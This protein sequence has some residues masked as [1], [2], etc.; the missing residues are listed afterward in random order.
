MMLLFISI[1]LLFS[2]EYVWAM[3]R[4][5]D[6]IS[7]EKEKE[8]EFPNEK[9]K[10]VKT[11][12]PE[13]KKTK[14]PSQNLRNPEE[15]IPSLCEL[16]SKKVIKYGNIKEDLKK[17]PSELGEYMQG[18]AQQRQSFNRTLF[19][20]AE[21]SE[22]INNLFDLGLD[23]NLKDD[24]GYTALNYLISQGK[25]NVVL[26]LINQFGSKL[27]VSSPAFD[28]STPLMNAIKKHYLDL[29]KNIIIILTEQDKIITIK[30]QDLE[31]NTA[32]SLAVKYLP[33][34][35]T[36]LIDLVKPTINIINQYL[37]VAVI[38]NPK[39]IKPLVDAGADV[40]FINEN[41]RGTPLL[42]AARYNLNSIKPLIKLGA[43]V[44]Y[45]TSH[46]ENAL[47]IAIEYNPES[48]KPLVDAGANVNYV[49]VQEVTPLFYAVQKNPNALQP[50]INAGADV[51]EIR[52]EGSALSQAVE[53]NSPQAIQTLVRA[54]ANLNQENSIN[55]TPLMISLKNA[56]KSSFI[57]LIQ[58]GAPIDFINSQ[59]KTALMEAVS[60]PLYLPE[61]LD[62]LLKNGASINM[63]NNE[64]KSALTH[65]I[66]AA[67]YYDEEE[68]DN[69]FEKIEFLLNNGASIRPIDIE[70]AL[71][72]PKIMQLLQE[73]L[74]KD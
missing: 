34:L 70:L 20:E 48:I 67:P 18:I 7:E 9:E 11:K 74:A 59:N 53:L 66:T 8:T 27:D 50:L 49:D 17:I 52:E 64:D 19:Y 24:S 35:I 12:E 65:A 32:L 61:D 31:G 62:L 39:S 42:A 38:N 45:K 5:K 13:Q 60:E 37:T 4:K 43:N 72:N 63:L 30:S 23:P 16:S 33:K 6:D 14:I 44:N 54:G 47:H 46:G 1:P 69:I 29:A 58:A 56:D 55:D 3:K 36:L 2:S 25:Y 28:G 15:P 21:N 73:H 68:F 10:E 57:A 22:D 41:T 26:A 40:N 51:N 71:G